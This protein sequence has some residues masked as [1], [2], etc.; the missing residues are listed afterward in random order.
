MNYFMITGIGNS[1]YS[2]FNPFIQWDTS[3]LWFESVN[4]GMSSSWGNEAV[5]YLETP[6]IDGWKK[7]FSE[8]K[9]NWVE[10]GGKESKDFFL[11]VCVKAICYES[12][13]SQRKMILHNFGWPVNA[14][15]V[16]VW[17][18]FIDLFVCSVLFLNS[19][20]F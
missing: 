20:D 12:N 18:S 10:N 9:E 15:E 1:I 17:W 4:D 8:K 16:Y 7:P 6:S 11:V 19:F 13:C 3:N 14:G 2:V 5:T